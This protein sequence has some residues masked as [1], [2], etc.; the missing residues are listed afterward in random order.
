MKLVW[1]PESADDVER[2]FH[3]LVG[4]NPSAAGRAMRTILQGADG[5]LEHPEAGVPLGDGTGRRELYLPF[6]AGAYVLRYRIHYED[7][8]IVRVWHSRESRG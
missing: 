3:F 2:L 6:G 5:L 7:V 4:K 1:L 8:V